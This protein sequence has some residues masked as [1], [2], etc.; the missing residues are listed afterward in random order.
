MLQQQANYLEPAHLECEQQGRTGAMVAV[1]LLQYIAARIPILRGGGARMVLTLVGGGALSS[2]SQVF[3]KSLWSIQKS[4]S[5]PLR[6]ASPPPSGC[7]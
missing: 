7:R 2:L 3:V 4:I 5:A 6:R 1:K